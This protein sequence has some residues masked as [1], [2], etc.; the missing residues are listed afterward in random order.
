MSAAA[1][2]CL[3]AGAVMLLAL[4]GAAVGG[5]SLRAESTGFFAAARLD[6]TN[7]FDIYRQICQGCHMPDGRGAVGAGAYPSL[8]ENPALAASQYTALT[9]LEGRRN[10]PGF[11]FREGS[12]F[13]FAPPTLTDE[14]V[15]GV[16]NYVRTHFGN[17]Y[18]DPITAAE[19]AVLH[20]AR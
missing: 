20:L 3:R 11:R 2:K 12:G 19:V 18:T 15:A 9:I 14:Q 7:G 10:M 16:V 17:H 4:L 13:F 1:G 6:T 8:A 5:G